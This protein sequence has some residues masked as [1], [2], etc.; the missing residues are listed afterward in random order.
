MP[1]DIERD[2]RLG[3]EVD[4]DLIATRGVLTGV[5]SE[6]KFGFNADVAN[7]EETVW[8]QG[9]LYS[10]LAAPSVLKISSSSTDDDAGGTGALTVEV[11]GQDTNNAEFSLVVVDD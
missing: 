5:T 1:I 10:C 11:F 3:K 8:D 7:S 9:G 6:R 4:L 2:W